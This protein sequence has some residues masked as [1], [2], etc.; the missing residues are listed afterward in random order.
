MTIPHIRVACHFINTEPSIDFSIRGILIP[1][2][3]PV[4]FTSPEEVLAHTTIPY[5]ASKL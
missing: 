3:H 4:D 2:S 5:R 1:V